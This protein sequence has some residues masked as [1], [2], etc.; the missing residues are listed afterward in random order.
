M[1]SIPNLFYPAHD[2]AL[3][4]GVRHFTP[5]QAAR[6][7]AEDLTELSSLWQPDTPLPWGWN[8]NTRKA[9]LEAGCAEAELPTM[10]D[11][12]LLRAWSGRAEVIG[13]QRRCNEHLAGLPGFEPLVLPRALRS[14]EELHAAVA[15]QTSPFLLKAPWSSSGRGL[16]WSRVTPHKVLLRRGEAIVRDMGCVLMEPEYRKVQDGA[17]LF[18]VDEERKVSFVGYSLFET[19]DMGTYREGR[20]MSL[21]AMEQELCRWVPLSLLHAVQALYC[22]EILPERCAKLSHNRYPLGYVGVDMM[23]YQTEAGKYALHPCVEMNVRCTMGVVARR[24]AQ[25]LLAP[26]ARGKFVIT[27]A[28]DAETLRRQLVALQQ[29]YPAVQSAAGLLHGFLPLTEVKT[30]SQFAAYLCAE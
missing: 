4:H 27:H 5:P 1:K 21:E 3:A 8:Y 22:C 10:G 24:A 2:L 20:V 15:E 12:E 25:R 6:R 14:A 28:P 7:L 13:W 23:I 29:K 17:M 18:Y 26:E 9:L 19:D 16:C 30:E 11:L